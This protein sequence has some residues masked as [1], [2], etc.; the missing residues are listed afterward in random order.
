MARMTRD[1]EVLILQLFWKRFVEAA[2]KECPPVCVFSFHVACALF[3]VP[4]CLIFYCVVHV[5]LPVRPCGAAVLCSPSLPV[6]PP[7][8][9]LFFFAPLTCGASFPFRST[10]LLVSSAPTIIM[11]EYSPHVPLSN[12]RHSRPSR[13]RCI[14]SCHALF[15]SPLFSF[16]TLFIWPVKI[17]IPLCFHPP[18]FPSRS[19]PLNSFTSSNADDSMPSQLRVTDIWGRP[20]PLRTGEKERGW[21]HP[22]KEIPKGLWA[23]PDDVP[24]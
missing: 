16:P 14:V 15:P 11:V 6:V 7:L 20:V 4:C 2:N 23:W 24:F 8:L 10:F 21:G 19:I 17:Y 12:R 13:R 3:P 5:P 22:I 1:S 18:E 9:L